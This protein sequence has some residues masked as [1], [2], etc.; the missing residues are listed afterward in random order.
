MSSCSVVLESHF[1]CTLLVTDND[2]E[3]TIPM[4]YL[5]SIS[6]RK[7]IT[8]DLSSNKLSGAVPLELDR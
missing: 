5:N 8:A 2:L 4:N 6:H 3:G 7:P 1:L